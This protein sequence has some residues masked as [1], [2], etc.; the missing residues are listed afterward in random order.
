MRTTITCLFGMAAVA[1]VVLL[2]MWWNGTNVL[3]RINA[4]S[5]DEVASCQRLI[6]G[7]SETIKDAR[8]ESREASIEAG[9]TAAGMYMLTDCGDVMERARDA[10][11]VEEE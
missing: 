10:G 8:K 7:F 5:A 4:P 11:M 3:A 9:I 2:A 1:V 6:D